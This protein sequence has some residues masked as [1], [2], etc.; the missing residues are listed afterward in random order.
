MRISKDVIFDVPEDIVKM[1]E[2]TQLPLHAAPPV[3][4][5]PD[6]APL[7]DHIDIPDHAPLHTP[8]NQTALPS[9]MRGHNM[10]RRSGKTVRFPPPAS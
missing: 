3:A 10:Q 9:A 6:S 2:A 1:M 8:V 7:V 5:P 4:A